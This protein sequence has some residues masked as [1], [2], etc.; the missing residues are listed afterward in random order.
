MTLLRRIAR[1]A[2]RLAR[3]SGCGSSASRPA[4]WNLSRISPG[5]SDGQLADQRMAQVTRDLQL[6]AFK[7]IQ[8]RHTNDQLLTRVRD[9]IARAS[10]IDQVSQVTVMSIH[11]RFRKDP[12]ADEPRPEVSRTAARRVP[13]CHQ[14]RRCIARGFAAPQ[15]RVRLGLGS[16]QLLLRMAARR[17]RAIPGSVDTDDR[18]RRHYVGDEPAGWVSERDGKWL[19][20]QLLDC[21]IPLAG[22]ILGHARRPGMASGARAVTSA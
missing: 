11:H 12:V 3:A 4:R 1:D 10:L 5:N 14:R 22:T 17:V 9:L 13:T 7:F 6:L 15:P 19:A 20:T 21:W 18:Y 8:L 2:C 16:G